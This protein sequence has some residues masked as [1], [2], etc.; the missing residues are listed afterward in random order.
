MAILTLVRH[1]QSVWNLEN[2]FTGWVD[3]DLTA[4]GEEEARRAGAALKAEGI[5]FNRCIVS[6]LKRARHT[7]A[8]LLENLGQNLPMVEA[9]EVI[10]RFYGGLTGLNKA[11][12]AAQYG[13]AQVHI[14]RRSYDIAPPELH[15]SSPH[16]P[17][18][19]PAFTNFSFALP[20]T[21]SLKDVVERVRPFYNNVLLPAL[22][23]GNNILVVA[24]GNSIRALIKEIKGLNEEQI[25]SVEIPTATPLCVEIDTSGRY[26]RDKILAINA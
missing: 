15:I 10:E 6:P 3:V 19:I 9:P 17:A 22:K 13:E 12:T 21:E 14:W 4:L 18:N 7:A 23:A 11:E 2:R 5:P 24:H 26:I 16:H 25:Q 1:G 20:A 8:L